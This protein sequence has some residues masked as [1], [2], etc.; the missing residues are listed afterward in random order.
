MP[1][2]GDMLPVQEITSLEA[3][4]EDAKQ[5]A[6]SA[7]QQAAAEQTMKRAAFA[8]AEAAEAALSA[9]NTDIQLACAEADDAQVWVTL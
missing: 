2:I 1:L 6:A 3:A 8:R 7:A 5:Q 4:R 9:A